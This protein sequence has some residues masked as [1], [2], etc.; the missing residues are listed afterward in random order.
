[1]VIAH[2]EK[3]FKTVSKSLWSRKGEVELGE[4]VAPELNR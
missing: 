4:G 2:R 3:Y 1:M